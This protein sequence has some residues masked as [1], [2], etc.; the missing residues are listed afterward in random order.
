[1]AATG[2]AF[3]ADTKRRL[4]VLESAVAAQP[5]GN[6]TLN[7][8]NAVEA[9][10]KAI[11][12]SISKMMTPD[13]ID[14]ILEAKL[15]TLKF[16]NDKKQSG[17]FHRKPI[18]ESKA[19]SDV[20]K[21]TD[22]KSYRPFNRKLKNAM[23]QVRPY[24]RKAMEMLET[25]TE[26]E[27]TDSALRDPKVS[28]KETIVDIYFAKHVTKYPDLEESLDEFNRD[29]WSVLDAKA[30]GEALGKL[31]SVQQGEGLMAFV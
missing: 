5:D 21:L 13:K 15:T 26:Q 30:E 2:E 27:I 12:D 14:L 16:M 28:V 6:V 4:D 29:I 25:I 23:E 7:L 24:A 18:L 1:M 3:V 31:K 17:D 9:R 10:V 8:V 22:A 19:V 11:E 20:D